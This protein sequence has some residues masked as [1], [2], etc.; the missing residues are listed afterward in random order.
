MIF[1]MFTAV[2]K[3]YLLTLS[4]KAWLKLIIFADL[5][6]ELLWCGP[7]NIVS[8][9]RGP[10]NNSFPCKCSQASKAA[11]YLLLAKWSYFLFFVGLR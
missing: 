6:Q 4:Q 9:N 1:K 7:V 2:Q 3:L 10:L 11:H 8:N 5:M